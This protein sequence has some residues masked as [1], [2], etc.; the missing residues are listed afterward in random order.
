MARKKPSGL[1]V[2][3]FKAKPAAAASE[4]FGAPTHFG[5]SVKSRTSGPVFLSRMAEHGPKMTRRARRRVNDKASAPI[6]GARAD[7]TRLIE[8]VE[9]D[10]NGRRRV[11]AVH[12]LDVMLKADRIRPDEHAAGMIYFEAFE[13]TQKSGGVDLSADRVDVS[14]QIKGAE[15]G[16]DRQRVY[17]DIVRIVPPASRQVCLHVCGHDKALRDGYSRDGHDAAVDRALL[18]EGLRALANAVS[19]GFVK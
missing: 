14:R 16:L 9:D 19:R 15:A 8:P 13:A 4:D 5:L 2:P 1:P 10:K 6:P 18:R 11:R 3:S 17:A 7:Q 12:Y